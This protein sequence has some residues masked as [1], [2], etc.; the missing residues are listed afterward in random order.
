ML[1]LNSKEFNTGSS[2]F[3]NGAAGKVN[4]VD[5]A[6]EKKKAGEPETY[7][8]YKL[9]VI[10]QA[11]NKLTQGFYYPK[12][13][14]GASPE[15]AK[16]SINTQVGRVIHIARAVLGEGYEFPS[17]KNAKEAFDMLFKLINDN[18]G[19]KKFNVFATYGTK[20]YPSK[21]L[22]LRYF[23]F[24]EPAELPAGKSSRLTVAAADQM[25]RI[26]EDAPSTGSTDSSDSSSDDE[27]DF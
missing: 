20:N 8:D 23:T 11:G 1:D 12:A 14:D 25:E 10:D 17:V 6:V 3:N 16:K 21:F 24:I 9:V 18:A 7:P 26:M 15:D 4:G 22:G 2:I 13:K 5:I 19:G 27:W